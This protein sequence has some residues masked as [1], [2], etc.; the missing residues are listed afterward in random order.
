VAAT[1]EVGLT[2]ESLEDIRRPSAILVVQRHHLPV[3]GLVLA[4]LLV[5]APGLVSGR[6]FYGKDTIQFYY[7][8]TEWF[9]A[10]VKAGTIPLWLPHIFG[11]YPLFADGE[12]GMAHPMV[13]VAAVL[14]T[15]ETAFTLLRYAH[16]ALAGVLMYWFATVLGLRPLGA[17]LAGLV[18]ALSSFLVGHMQHDNILRSAVWLPALLACAELALRSAGL[19]RLRYVLFAGL[20]LGIQLLGVHIQ[21]VLISLLAATGWLIVGPLGLATNEPREQAA[22]TG[23]ARRVLDD[24]IQRVSRL[25]M[26]GVIVGVGLLLAAVQILPLAIL[27]SRTMRGAGVNYFVSTSYAFSPPELLTLLFPY[28]FRAGP[29]QHW[30]L[31]PP[32]ETTLYVGVLP[33]ALALVAVLFVRSRLVVWLTIGALVHL[34]LALGDYVTPNPYYLLWNLPGFAVLRAPARFSLVIILALGCLAGLGADWLNSRLRS[35]FTKSQV[36]VLRTLAMLVAGLLAAVVGLG[37]SVRNALE[38]MP[39]EMMQSIDLSYLALRREMQQLGATNVAAGLGAAAD[40][41]NPSTRL[42]LIWIGLTAVVFVMWSMGQRWRALASGLVV[43]VTAVDLLTF[44]GA[45]YPLA[46]GRDLQAKHPVV[47][48]LITRNDAEHVL[49][50]PELHNL[51]GANQLV[52]HGISVAGGYS[53]LEPRRFLDYWWGMVRDENVLLD[54]FNVRYLV[55]PREQSGALMFNE[56]RFHHAERLVNGGPSNPAGA[57]SL[58]APAVRADQLTVISAVDGMDGAET[59]EPIA[60]VDLIGVAGE[61][62]QHVLRYGIELT[63]YQRGAPNPTQAN[64][65][66]YGPSFNPL[67]RPFPVQ[68]SGTTLPIDPPMQVERVDVRYLAPAGGFLLHGL[69]LRD[70]DT[71]VTR[72][73]SSA[74][75]VKFRQVYSDDDVV[76]LENHDAMPKVYFRPGAM[77]TSVDAPLA[78]DLVSAPLDLHQEIVLDRDNEGLARAP[79]SGA[80][81]Q[82]ELLRYGA[83]ELSASVSSS[84]D[85][86]LVIGD[87]FDAGWRAWVDGRE[88][89]V[90]RANAVMRAV[91][92]GVGQHVVEMRYEPWWVKFGLIIT[93]V[94]L[95]AIVT[96]LVALTHGRARHVSSRSGSF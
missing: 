38:A 32:Q 8:L 50:D 23:L 56:T 25:W 82:A 48:E 31:W 76:V 33:L 89:P 87:R 92:V 90:F 88:A 30:S 55:V 94:S 58:R 61:Q 29:E 70:A 20:V 86:F 45:F 4:P 83:A 7:P 43:I 21:P 22:R 37:V 69:G 27:A 65:A 42:A 78:H 34:W 77:T 60:Q 67:G 19:A 11:G 49:L 96:A 2:V 28:F 68:L 16:F 13:L 6:V 14:F 36:F 15:A 95:L 39:S 66:Y 47:Q 1:A 44:A 74:D 85:G 46:N 9:V 35:G 79:T 24:S 12:I 93:L 84:S 57:E 41:N 40:F 3:L 5:F 81:G 71:S 59:G 10:Q 72:S 64:W 52:S 91:P 63:G 51:I 53:S 73:L 75:R 18:F 26:W 54:L 80:H 17:S 62:Q